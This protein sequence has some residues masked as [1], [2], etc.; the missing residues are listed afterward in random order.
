MP[1]HPAARTGASRSELIRRAIRDRYGERDWA[2]RRAALTASA[3]A[4][5][6]RGLTGTEYVDA[7]RG[8]LNTRLE[9]LGWP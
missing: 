8:D 3:G 1:I 4:W 2:T 6:D 7:L 9:R 5:K